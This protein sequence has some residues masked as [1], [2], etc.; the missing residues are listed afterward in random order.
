MTT[1]TEAKTEAIKE[2]LQTAEDSAN[3]ALDDLEQAHRILA[4]MFTS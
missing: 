2:Y 3:L 4:L 1:T